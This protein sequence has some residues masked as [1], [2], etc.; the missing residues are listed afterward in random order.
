MSEQTQMDKITTEFAEHICDNLCI[1]SHKNMG[2]DDLDE[3]CDCCKMGQ[4]ICDI[5]NEYNR[6]NDFEQT[7]CCKLLKKISELEGKEHK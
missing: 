5:L 4:F 3:I 6:L 7:E 2:Q 1:Y